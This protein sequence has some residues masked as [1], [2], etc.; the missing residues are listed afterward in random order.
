L[1]SPHLLFTAWPSPDTLPQVWWDSALSDFFPLSRLNSGRD[2]TDRPDDGGS[3]GLWKVGR[4]VPVY[5]ALQPR[6]WPPS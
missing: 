3:S 5:R 6:R 4:L 1:T 2:F